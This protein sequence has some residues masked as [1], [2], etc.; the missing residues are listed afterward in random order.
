[1][2]GNPRPSTIWILICLVGLNDKS[3]I[4]TQFVNDDKTILR[5]LCM[6]P[7]ALAMKPP[8]DSETDHVHWDF[9]RPEEQTHSTHEN[10]EDF[11]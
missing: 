5:H 4:C 10:T 11:I 8:T 9:G 3:T 7:A 1:M 2:W 6:D